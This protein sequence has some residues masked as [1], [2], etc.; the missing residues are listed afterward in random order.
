MAHK[1]FLHLTDKGLDKSIYRIMSVS[2]LIECL[3]TKQLVLVKPKLWDDPFENYLLSATVELANGERGTL[4]PIRDS[5]FGQCWTRHRETDAMWRIYSHD[6][7]GVR[8]KSSPRKLFKALK[9]ANPNYGDVTCFIGRVQ[10]HDKKGLISEL[11]AIELMRSNGSGIAESLLHKRK[12]FAHEKEVRL[13]H[14]THDR[15]LAKADTY[16]FP[17]D[18]NDL[19]EQAIFDPRMDR[20]D[21]LKAEQEL[22]RRGYRKKVGQSL[23]YRPPEELV[24][25][26]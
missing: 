7:N 26:L 4:G 2:R 10:Y 16:L 6:K 11:Q 25:K 17:V 8:V 18:P 5:V 22:R 21:Y 13:I 3:T 1:N 24:I 19:F 15:A 23:L 9:D 12:E 20:S 14:N